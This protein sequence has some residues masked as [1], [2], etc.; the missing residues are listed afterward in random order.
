MCGP[1]PLPGSRRPR[2]LNDSFQDY[3][4][5][6][7]SS[8]RSSA[9]QWRRTRTDSSRCTWVPSSR[10][11]ARRAATPI[12]LIILPRAP[13]RIPFW[14]SVL[15]EHHGL[16]PGQVRARMGDVLHLDLDGM[17]DLLPRARQHLLADELGE[18]HR[19]R[20]VRAL[21]G[22]EV[23][24]PAGEQPDQVVHQRRDSG[25]GARADRE[26]LG[27]DVQRLG[28]AG[29]SAAMRRAFSARSTLLTATV[30]GIPARLRRPAMK[31]SPGPTPCWALTMS[32]TPSASPSSCSTR[33]CIRSVSASRGRWTPGR[34]TRMSCQSGPLATPRMARR[35][36]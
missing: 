8:T 6:R 16:D 4:L 36:V 30:T 24:R 12:D 21:S 2:R 29:R 31:R 9:R 14:D 13:M 18:Q 15:G 23:E 5:P 17:G 35:V 34:S 19:G 27:G 26:D 7:R 3:S 25:A 10:S 22:G 28:V 20:L 11:M 33:C 32:R 1:K